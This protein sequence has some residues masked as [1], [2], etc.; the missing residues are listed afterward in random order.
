MNED[1]ECLINYATTHII[2]WDKTYFLKLTLI[3]ANVS[4]TSGT[5]NLVEGFRR[6]NILLP[7][8]TRFHIN[9]VLY[10][11]KS[12][13]NFLSFKDIRR[14]GYHIEIM[15]KGNVEYRY[16]TFIIYD[17]KLMVEKLPTFFSKCIIQL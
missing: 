12:R 17:Q 2:L 13:I 16:I 8:I 10:S 5:T 1:D 3:K 7:N 9:D 11:K 14:S 15:N 6:A 4:T